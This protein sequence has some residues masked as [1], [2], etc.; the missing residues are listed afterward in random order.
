[1]GHDKSK[2]VLRISQAHCLK[3]SRRMEQNVLPLGNFRCFILHPALPHVV[4]QRVFFEKPALQLENL[5]EPWLDCCSAARSSVDGFGVLSRLRCSQDLSLLLLNHPFDGSATSHHVRS[6]L[7]LGDWFF[8]AT[9]RLARSLTLGFFP[10]A[11]EHSWK[12]WPGF[13]I[14]NPCQGICALFWQSDLH[15]AIVRLGLDA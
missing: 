13:Q 6:L 11:T 9:N 2:G 5:C 8:W 3:A 4:K 1:M 7:S 14:W 12:R 10:P 15:V